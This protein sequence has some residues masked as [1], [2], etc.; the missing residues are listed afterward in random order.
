MNK[1]NIRKVILKIRDNSFR[2]L[3]LLAC[4]TCATIGWTSARYTSDI[5]ASPDSARTAE[6]SYEIENL[7]YITTEQGDVISQEA[8]MTDWENI[9]QINLYEL[10]QSKNEKFKA[11]F[12]IELQSEATVKLDMIKTIEGTMQPL[13]VDSVELVIDGK[14]AET[15]ENPSTP[16][17]APMLT[18]T[19][20][21]SANKRAIQ[22][23]VILSHTGLG[24]HHRNDLNLIPVV[25]QID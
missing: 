20:E 14:V 8:S 23:T 24:T 21:P 9:R 2:Y 17:R 18:Y 25:T 15:I 1:G 4:L 19:L 22:W 16:N 10:D 13:D 7:T 11:V 5:Y 12:N 6:F 3:F